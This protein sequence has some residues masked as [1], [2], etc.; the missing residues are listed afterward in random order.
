MFLFGQNGYLISL[1]VD[2]CINSEGEN[3]QKMPDKQ[4]TFHPNIQ[5]PEQNTATENVYAYYNIHRT[6]VEHHGD[7]VVMVCWSFPSTPRKRPWHAAEIQCQ[8]P[9]DNHTMRKTHLM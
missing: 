1:Y 5:L 3:R 4:S 2:I 9:L 8:S 7:R 6:I